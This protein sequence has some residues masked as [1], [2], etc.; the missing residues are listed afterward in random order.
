MYPKTSE[1]KI[2]VALF[3]TSKMGTKLTFNA[4]SC[5]IVAEKPITISKVRIKIAFFVFILGIL[6]EKLLK[7]KNDKSINPSKDC[8]NPCM[9][10]SV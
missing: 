6:K 2:P 10:I 7:N 1:N 4:K 9:Y 5:V 8:I 3:T